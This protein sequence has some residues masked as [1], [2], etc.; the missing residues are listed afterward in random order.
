MIVVEWLEYLTEAAG[1]RG[2][3][4]AIDYYEEIDWVGPDVADE[5][6]E[7]LRGFD[8]ADGGDDGLTID[9]HTTSLEYISQLDGCGG[10]SAALSQLVGGGGGRGLQ[11]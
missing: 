7:Y 1:Y 8:E 6:Q 5:L 2:T 3:A 11:R 10:A 9:D 4:R